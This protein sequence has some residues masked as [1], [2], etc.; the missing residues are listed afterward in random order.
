[1]IAACGCRVK[2]YRAK[3]CPNCEKWL[4]P[5]CHSE[6]ISVPGVYCPKNAVP[7]TFEIKDKYNKGETNAKIP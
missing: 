4:C 7:L 6:H 5:A 2:S 1:M 3:Q